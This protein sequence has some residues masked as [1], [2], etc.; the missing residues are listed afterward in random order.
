MCFAVSSL[1]LGV[2]TSEVGFTVTE[3]VFAKPSFCHE[4]KIF[5]RQPSEAARSTAGFSP[6]FLTSLLP[7]VLQNVLLRGERGYFCLC[8]LLSVITVTANPTAFKTR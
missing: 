7:S 6:P 5:H 3:R 1:F 8:I 4:G 2:F